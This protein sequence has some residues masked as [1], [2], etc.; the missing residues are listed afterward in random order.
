MGIPLLLE[1]CCSQK[2]VTMKFIFTLL[3]FIT[4]LS[5]FSQVSISGTLSSNSIANNAPAKVVDSFVTITGSSPIDGFK[6]SV[7][8]NFSNG[9][10]LAYTGVLPSGVTAGYN[11]TTGVLIFTGSAMPAAFRE[12]LRTVTFNTTSSS[13][14]QRTITFKIDTAIAYSGNGHFYRFIPGG[15][16]WLGAKSFA[17]GQSFYGLNGY[18]ATITS[19]A[20]N[21]FIQQKLSADG[22]IGASDEFSAINTATAPTNTYTDQAAA[23]GKWYWVTGPVGEIG[24]NFSNSNNNP[25]LVTGKFMNWATPEPNNAGTGEHY[26]AILST[27]ATPGKWNDLNST[28]TLGFVVEYGGMANDPVVTLTFSR[29]ITMITTSL[30]TTASTIAYKLH[31]AAIIVDNT[32]AVYS[33]ASIVNAKVTIASNFNTGDALGYTAGSLPSGVTVVNNAATGVL[34]FTG[35]ATASQWQALFR[36]V[37]FNSSSNIKV[38]RVVSFSAGNFV[39]GSNGHF[40]NYVSTLTAWS[41]AKLNA[42]AQIYLGLHGYLATIT[43]QTENDFIKQKFGSDAFIGASDAYDVINAASGSGIYATQ[44]AATGKWYWVGGPVGEKGVQ[45]STGNTP[46][47]AFGGN[48]M[49][50][51]SGEPDNTGGSEH[52]CAMS[53]SGANPGRWFDVPNTN[54][55]LGYIVEY[56]GLATDPVLNL[57]ASRTIAINS[58]LPITGLN[59][60][61]TKGAKGVELKWSTNTETNSNHFDILYSTD[62]NSFTR[63][64]QVAASGNTITTTNYQWVHNNPAYGNNYYRLQEFDIDNRSVLSET[65]NVYMGSAKISLSPNPVTGQFTLS[66]PYSGIPVTMTIMNSAGKMVM[67]VRIT[68]YQTTINSAALAPGLYVAVISENNTLT[69]LTFIRK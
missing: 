56:G 47:V 52:Y 40:Y 17:A 26:G 48:Y 66:Y 29:N 1:Q 54:N 45:F 18:L 58:I 61:A 63:I 10:V 35:T 27:G 22:W 9:D 53:A 19:Q 55:L 4:S 49:N 60:S 28:T 41:I 62:G 59:F 37:T 13:T 67:K 20:E 50:W 6:V 39:A 30:Q 34:S 57:S 8:T 31:A 64:G 33:T 46:P 44:A 38:N 15:F 7:A 16:N 2:S 51:T 25:I 5:V 32:A 21:D 42:E 43:S 3:G 36:T 69:K 14:L 24:T 12:L 11:A 23:E 65:R 68:R